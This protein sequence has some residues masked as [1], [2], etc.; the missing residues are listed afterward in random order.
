MFFSREEASCWHVTGRSWQD[1]SS[2]Y[3]EPPHGNLTFPQFYQKRGVHNTIR[4]GSIY[5]GY[6]SQNTMDR[7]F[8]IP[9]VG[10]KIPWVGDSIYHG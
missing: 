9:W 4:E 10:V 5:H 7:G 8:D 6:G 3:F 1:F 2:M